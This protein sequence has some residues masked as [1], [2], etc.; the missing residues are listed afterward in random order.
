MRLVIIGAIGIL[1]LT[2][3]ATPYQAKSA[4]IL[5]GGYQDQDMGDGKFIVAYDGNGYT[6]S[7]SVRMFAV[8]RAKELCTQSGFRTFT[9]LN[10]DAGADS[11]AYASANRYGGTFVSGSF[12]HITIEVQCHN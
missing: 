5:R 11:F 1:C 6:S 2:G 4:G 8:R 10:G 3:C 9:I 12:P 7:A